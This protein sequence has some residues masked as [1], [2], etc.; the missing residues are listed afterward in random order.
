[1]KTK[2]IP[3]ILTAC[4]V[5]LSSCDRTDPYRGG[6]VFVSGEGAFIT[7]DFLGGL[8]I[9]EDAGT[10]QVPVRVL[11]NHGNFSVTVQTTD[12]TAKNGADFTILEP[13]TG[14]LAFGEDDIVKFITLGIARG[15]VGEYTE[16]G[17]K[18]FQISLTSATGG[19]D[20]GSVR[21]ATA[22]INDAD[23][24]LVDI[25]G[26]WNASADDGRGIGS[27]TM[28]LM[29]VAGDLEKLRINGIGPHFVDGYYVD[30]DNPEK[31]YDYTF[32]VT[33]TGEEGSRQF[34]I[35][36]GKEMKTPDDEGN[37]LSLWGYDG[38]YVYN[39]GGDLVFTQ[40]EDGSFL[41]DD[42]WGYAICFIEDDGITA[43]DV[44]LP[45]TFSMS[46]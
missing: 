42:G 45:D 30:P 3:L 19:I 8:S 28:T 43:Y 32:V 46:R 18:D 31:S 4:A 5:V 10:F 35:P 21:K 29:P 15:N 6:D 36:F 2:Y 25:I 44:I 33:V 23:H 13:A 14:V 41:I 27:W 20:L 17:T 37:I 24:P 1:M 7:L 12:G 16:P 22:T 11:G 26:G 9:R 39:S 40:Q 34:S 38:T